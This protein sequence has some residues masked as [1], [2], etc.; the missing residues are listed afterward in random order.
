MNVFLRSP[1]FER[2]MVSPIDEQE[3]LRQQVHYV[4]QN[5]A[6]PY[7]VIVLLYQTT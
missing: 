1:S 2:A 7:E 5:S 6:K 4:A 3:S